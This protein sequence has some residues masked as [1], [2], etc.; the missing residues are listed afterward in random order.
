VPA[1]W[2]AGEHE[3]DAGDG[4]ADGAGV[5][6]FAGVLQ[7][8]AEEGVRG[9]ADAEVFLAGEGDERGGGVAVDGEGFFVINGFAVVEGVEGYLGVGGGDGEVED[10]VDFLALEELLRGED[11]G[12]FEGGGLCL[13]AGGVEIGEGDDF[14]VRE[15]GGIAE[16]DRADVAAADEADGGWI[17]DD[18]RMGIGREAS[19]ES[20]RARGT[21]RRPGRWT[22][23]IGN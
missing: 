6:E 18:F 19:R 12:D 4:R 15:A 11:G 17:F 14:Q 16:V 5:E 1:L 9:A 22:M 13:G 20:G 21:R 8:G 3:G 10:D 7:A 2:A 23:P